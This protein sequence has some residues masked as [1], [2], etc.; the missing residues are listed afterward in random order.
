MLILRFYFKDKN[1]QTEINGFTIIQESN[2]YVLAICKL[3][4]REWNFKNSSPRINLGC[5]CVRRAQPIALPEAINGFKIITDLGRQDSKRN[6]NRKVVARC[7][8]CNKDFVSQISNLKNRISC[9]C[10]RKKPFVCSFRKSHKR[11][12]QI[13]KCMRMRCYNESHRSYRIYGAVGIVVCDEW[14]A[15]ADAFCKW[16]LANGYKDGLSIDRI[17]GLLNYSPE[18]CRWATITQQNRNARTNVMTIELARKIRAEDSSLTR[19]SIADKY[20]VSRNTITCI[21][22]NKT[23][24]EHD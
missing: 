22:L 3:C 18:N 20:N 6:P 24:K 15:D 14:M 5:G 16:A 10:W 11:L 19:Q 17:D 8:R 23:W 7:H 9:G 4:G 13:Y 12:V 21:L 2:D 1:V